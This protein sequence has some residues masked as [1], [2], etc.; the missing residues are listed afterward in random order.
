L[1]HIWAFHPEEDWPGSV[2]VSVVS[3]YPYSESWRDKLKA[4]W[5][6]LRGQ[7]WVDEMSFYEA[8]TLDDFMSDLAEARKVL[9]HW[10][11]R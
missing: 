1:A 8:E 5:R 4:I 2:H 7:L 3:M 6:I 11:M 10:R 9:E